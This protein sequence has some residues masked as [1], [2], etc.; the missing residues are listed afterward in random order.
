M[1]EPG[2]PEPAGTAPPKHWSTL[3]ELR[4]SADVEELRGREFFTPPA[5]EESELPSRREFL[6]FLGAG[7]AFAAAGCARKPVEKILPYVKAPE[8][9]S[10]GNAIYFASTC[11]DCPAACGTLVK[12]REGRPIKIEG[13]K[14]HPMS[15]GALCARGQSSILNLYDPDRLRGPALI[16][17]AK[18]STT[19]AGWSEIDRR[20][21]KALGEARDRGAKVVFLTGTIVSPTTLTLI[22][23]FLGAFQ[24][25]EHVVYDAVSSDALAKAQ[26]LCYGGRIIPRYRL[27]QADV[28]VTFG[29]DPLG[30]FLSPVEFARDFSSRRRPEAGAMSRF[31]AIE[32]ILSLS[33]TNAD[34]HL[35]V[36]PDHLYPVAMALGHELLVREP[37]SPLSSNAAA[38]AA[39]SPFPA[40]SVEKTAGLEEGALARVAEELARA[41]GK[42][43]VLAGPQAAPA[44]HAVALQVAVN[45][46]N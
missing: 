17:R 34:S 7:A 22:Q 33:G 16:D 39:V 29:A 26:E 42:G 37:R 24:G 31:I 23:S 27:D 20:A 9:I 45:L 18:G 40:A 38:V 6:K 4:G 11:S 19:A 8:E 25:A 28:L 5:Q 12:T 2:T 21:A 1:K 14:S 36:R 44:E 32:P 15:R 35:R 10:P 41:R 30:T 3:A 13:N 46:L 43:L